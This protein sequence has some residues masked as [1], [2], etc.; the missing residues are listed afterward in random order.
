M[1]TSPIYI[2]PQDLHHREHQHCRSGILR[3]CERTGIDFDALMSG[4]VT[5]AE[6]FDVDNALGNEVAQNAELRVKAERNIRHEN[7]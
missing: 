2:L 4:K 5:S 7:K 1:E 3:F 6:M